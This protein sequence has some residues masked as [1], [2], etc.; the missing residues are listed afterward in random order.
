MRLTRLFVL[1]SIALPVVAAAATRIEIARPAARGEVI[2]V[3]IW[4][5]GT[6]VSAQDIEVT[7]AQSLISFSSPA[8]DDAIVVAEGG[9]FI[10]VTTPLRVGD[11]DTIQAKVFAKTSLTLVPQVSAGQVPKH[12]VLELSTC[13][14]GK[15]SPPFVLPLAVDPERLRVDA[16]VPA[17]CFNLALDA[18]GFASVD[19]GRR[20][21]EAGT[22][23][24]LGHVTLRPGARVTIR[25]VDADAAPVEGVLVVA[26]STLELART[27]SPDQ[28]DTPRVLAQ[29][30]TDEKGWVTLDDVPAGRV[31]FEMRARGRRI[32]VRSD[33]W[34]IELGRD[35]IVDPLE[36]PSPGSVAVTAGLP[37][38][39]EELLEIFGVRVRTTEPRPSAWQTLVEPIGPDGVARFPELSPGKWVATISGRVRDGMAF[40]I[41]ET[42]LDVRSGH[43]TLATVEFD[44]AIVRGRLEKGGSLYEMDG[45]L[46]F[47][48]KGDRGKPTAR[49]KAG[50]FVV[51]LERGAKYMPQ[52]Q[53]PRRQPTLLTT[54]VTAP[55]NG[56]LIIDLPD[57]SI[58]GRVRNED[59]TPARDAIVAAVGTVEEGM[60]TS[61][62]VVVNADEHGDFLLDLV[63]EGRWT[64]YAH[65]GD[66]KSEPLP[67]ELRDGGHVTG[68]EVVIGEAGVIK[69]RLTGNFHQIPGARVTVTFL[70]G[71]SKGTT[72]QPVK[73]GQ[74]G[75]F[76]IPI[77]ADDR[78]TMAN[79][80]VLAGDRTAFS[81]RVRLEDGL[82]LAVPAIA[83]A[84]VIRRTRGAWKSDRRLPVLVAPDGSS[85]SAFV[86]GGPDAS[87]ATAL[88]IPRLAGGTWRVVEAHAGDE[89]TLV[90][91]GRADQLPAVA[92]IEVVEGQTAE[93]VLP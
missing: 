4:H 88:Y 53:R 18:P 46:S 79:L 22:P 84:V 11:D 67:I 9:D 16:A 82:T 17:G 28:R 19:L 93:V 12:L 43:E 54:L 81:S 40:E 64:L 76:E 44:R 60:T 42:Q 69:A 23:L 80:M 5:E 26:R 47:R 3:T 51:N 30:T 68:I 63:A 48:S 34:D 49:V 31:V 87:D 61:P 10:A 21:L 59:G 7:D 2:H 92:T 91:Q 65:D 57:G 72:L 36:L 90:R 25:V 29:G 77:A 52:I 70:G 62:S 6:L 41:G 74:G 56:E 35:L 37:D 50:V 89:L 85:I 20:E 86:A 83:G 33:A 55:E 8:L 78:G 15:S 27:R 66:R 13:K 39:A 75:A 45:M 38:N 32:P 14:H 73:V 1:L 24:D 71:A 58:E